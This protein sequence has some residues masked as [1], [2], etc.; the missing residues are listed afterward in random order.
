MGLHE[1][2]L[3][4]ERSPGIQGEARCRWTKSERASRGGRGGGGPERRLRGSVTTPTRLTW[5]WILHVGPKF[6]C[7]KAN[8]TIGKCQ[9]FA[10]E[11]G[12]I[13]LLVDIIWKCELTVILDWVNR[14][15]WSAPNG[16]GRLTATWLRQ[17]TWRP[18][19]A[20]EERKLA[21]HSGLFLIHAARSHGLPGSRH[22]AVSRASPGR[23]EMFVEYEDSEQ[24]KA[25]KGRL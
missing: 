16:A 22:N 13:R 9:Q 10:L 7:A 8:Q 6:A 3:R 2:L 14:R 1:Q 12:A 25:P 19:G 4:V 11:G 5:V 20:W 18:Y 23:G 24:A 15:P 21:M 17:Q